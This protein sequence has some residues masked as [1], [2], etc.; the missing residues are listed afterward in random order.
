MFHKIDY[1]TFLCM[2]G[3]FKNEVRHANSF[4]GFILKILTYLGAMRG[5][6]SLTVSTINRANASDTRHQPRCSSAM[7]TNGLR[8]PTLDERHDAFGVASPVYQ[9][10]AS[11]VG[12]AR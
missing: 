2:L 1:H 12:P 8:C 11:S 5:L 10:D 7:C 4:N 3:G 9:G 6:A